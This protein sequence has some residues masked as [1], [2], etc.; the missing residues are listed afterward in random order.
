ME[1]LLDTSFI[2]TAL[3]EKI[4]FLKAEEYGKLLLPK[5]VL[6]ELKKLNKKARIKDRENAR[7]ALE[8]ITKNKG[9]FKFI[10]LKKKYADA[11]IKRYI[12][13]KKVIVATLDRELKRELKGKAKILTI[14]AK[15]KLVLI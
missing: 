2:L 15:K 3:K 6:E 9:K 11:G 13:N 14:R 8:I 4:D 12:K 7:L 5:Q 10:K 1:V